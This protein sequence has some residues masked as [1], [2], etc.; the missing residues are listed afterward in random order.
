MLI[1]IITNIYWGLQVSGVVLP[2]VY[3]LT[4]LILTLS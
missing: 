3:V 2:A 1:T 4:H